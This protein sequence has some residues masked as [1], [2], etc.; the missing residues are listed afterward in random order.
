M[1]F[2]LMIRPPPRSTP[3]DTLCPYTTRFRSRTH[4]MTPE[5][6]AALEAQ[7]SRSPARNAK[8]S[9]ENIGRFRRMQAKLIGYLDGLPATLRKYPETDTSLYGRYR[10]EGHTSELQPLMR[11]S[12]SVFRF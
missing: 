7:L 6:V 1:C 3:T 9:P 8:D 4:P 5:R 10:S 12:Y 2:Y 11:I